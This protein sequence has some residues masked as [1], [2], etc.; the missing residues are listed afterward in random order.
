MSTDSVAV[1]VVKFFH[2]VNAKINICT[3]RR[4]YDNNVAVYFADGR[5]GICLIEKCEQ[6][7]K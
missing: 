4:R 7:K 6:K 5:A 3:P 1:T 2:F